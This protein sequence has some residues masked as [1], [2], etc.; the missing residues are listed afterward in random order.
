[1]IRKSPGKGPRLSNRAP[2]RG[3]RRSLP[4]NILYRTAISCA[5]GVAILWPFRETYHALE[6]GTP[7]GADRLIAPVPWSRRAKADARA[8]PTL[9]PRIHQV[10]LAVP[11][12]RRH[13]FT[14][15]VSM[16]PLDAGGFS[17]P[18]P[19]RLRS[20]YRSSPVSCSTRK[21]MNSRPRIGNWR[22]NACNAKAGSTGMARFGRTSTRRPSFR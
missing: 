13:P 20:A 9:Q 16:M 3:P 18:R 6:I 8:A 14:Q 1:M 22:P 2:L 12:N 5:S 11:N 15:S 10:S 17:K 4:I 19:S 7:V 21:S